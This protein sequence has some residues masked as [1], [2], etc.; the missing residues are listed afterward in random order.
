IECSGIRGSGGE[1]ADHLEGSSGWTSI[2]LAHRLGD[3]AAS[4]AGLRLA[5]GPSGARHGAA[6]HPADADP[7]APPLAE[8]ATPAMLDDPRLALPDDLIAI[9]GGADHLLHDREDLARWSG[10]KETPGLGG[11]GEHAPDCSRARSGVRRGSR[12]IAS[13]RVTLAHG[14]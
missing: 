4:R 10:G 2:S 3:Q 11:G 12:S 6:A 8:Q 5:P 7:G 14:V 1:E 9:G 13:D